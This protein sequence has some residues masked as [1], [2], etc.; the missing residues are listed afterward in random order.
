MRK[1]LYYKKKGWKHSGKRKKMR[2]I[3]VIKVS[4]PNVEWE[5]NLNHG[6]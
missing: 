5:K 2:K 6:S 4:L 1:N 3:K